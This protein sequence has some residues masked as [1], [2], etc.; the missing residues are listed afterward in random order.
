M[1]LKLL[2]TVM[3]IG[4]VLS[5]VSIAG[6][7]I[8][9]PAY[10][11]PG[12]NSW[13]SSGI[14]PVH[15]GGVNYIYSGFDSSAFTDLYW[16][17]WDAT[18]TSATLDGTLH[19]LAFSGVSGNTA[20][21]TGTTSW[22]DHNVYPDGQN[23][24]S[25]PIKLDITITGTGSWVAAAGLGLTGRSDYVWDTT[26]GQDYTANLQFLA[27]AGSGMKPLDQFPV[28][29]YLNMQAN[30]W[31][32]FYSIPPAFLPGDANR[33]G[34]VNVADLTNLLN[35]YNK[36]GKNWY[37][38]DFN[39]DTIVNVADLTLLLNNYNKTSGAGV[40]ADT[41]VPE[42]SSI[43]MLGGIAVMGLLYWWR[44]QA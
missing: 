39:G 5:L 35:N 12:G 41:A 36:T 19:N 31:G 21:W 16:G 6:A 40:V 4:Y 38:G 42:P 27:D 10:P 18:T 24:P 8:I 34:T 28:Q 26:K 43:A 13:A 33:D 23:Y 30:F 7:V 3:A 9:G 1:S 20:T 15:L 44:K 37:N 29:D 22:Y 17:A 11:A 25:I 32:G 14:L 2:Q